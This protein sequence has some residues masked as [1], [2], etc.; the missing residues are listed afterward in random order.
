MNP[1]LPY[2]W[3]RTVLIASLCLNLLL[4][5]AAGALIMRWRLHP[6]QEVSRLALRQV[7]RELDRDDARIVRRAFIGQR[8][9]LQ[10]DYTGYRRSLKAI[11]VALQETPRNEDKLQAA[12]REAR[13]KRIALSDLSFDTL[14]GSVQN[15]S[16]AGR[17]ALLKSQPQ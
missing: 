3:I 11:L 12:I 2:R 13:S 8:E 17:D 14:L 15:I 4:A 6:D 5:G 9:Q 7:T 16:P 1:A 10:Q